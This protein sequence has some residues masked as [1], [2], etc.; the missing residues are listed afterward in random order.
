MN[1]NEYQKLAARTLIDKPGFKITDDEWRMIWAAIRLC[2]LAGSIAENVKKGVFHRHGVN[3]AKLRSDL[4]NLQHVA[5]SAYQEE[6]YAGLPLDDREI[7]QVWNLIGLVGETGEIATS[8][9]EAFFNGFGDV[10]RATLTK[11]IGDVEWYAAALCT[12]SDIEL[13]AV[14]EQNIKKLRKRYPDGYTSTDSKARVDVQEN[15]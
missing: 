14:M 1:A 12:R 7:M 15:S 10:D 8:F 2:S 3:A 5:I 11:E 6:G 13:G 4:I 9:V